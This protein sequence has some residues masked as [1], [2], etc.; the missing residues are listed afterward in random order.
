M[1]STPELKYESEIIINTHSLF[2]LSLATIIMCSRVYL[3]FLLI[4]TPSGAV[5]GSQKES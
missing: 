4:A 5:G 1:H 2:C 3:L